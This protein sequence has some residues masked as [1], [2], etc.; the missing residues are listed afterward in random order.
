MVSVAAT[1]SWGCATVCRHGSV[2]K[3]KKLDETTGG[4][5]ATA[6]KQIRRSADRE[7]F[8][9]VHARGEAARNG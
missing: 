6:P 3:V 2:G 4:E 1:L 9:V 7:D 8:G 5:I